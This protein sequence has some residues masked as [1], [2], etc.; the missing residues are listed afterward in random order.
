MVKKETKTKVVDKENYIKLIALY[1]VT[2][3]AVLGITNLYIKNREARLKEPLIRGHI[4]EVKLADMKSFL[5]ENPS[6]VLYFGVAHERKCRLFEEDLIRVMKKN[7]FQ[8][9]LY[10]VNLS[11]TKEENEETVNKFLKEYGYDKFFEYNNRPLIVE[12]NT[13]KIKTIIYDKDVNL[14][15][16]EEIFKS[17]A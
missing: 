11:G 1:V 17:R 7:L 6:A 3:L 8:H 14:D 4:Q 9:P 16:V 12:M 15:T 5:V 13:P 10:Y 2:I